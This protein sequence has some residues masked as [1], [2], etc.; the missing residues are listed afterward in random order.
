MGEVSLIPLQK[1]TGDKGSVFHIIKDPSFKIKEVYVSTVDQNSV[2]GWKKHLK[3][4]LNLVVIK[5]DV[6]FTIKKNSK[7]YQYVIGDSNYCRLVVAPKCWVC[8]EGVGEEN[9][10]INCADLEHVPSETEIKPFEGYDENI[11]NRL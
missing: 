6:K 1:I 10:I 11:S 7:T 5:G 8:F 2:K 4:T 3:M 9:I